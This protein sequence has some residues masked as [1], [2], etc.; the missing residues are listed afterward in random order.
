MSLLGRRA[1]AI[2]VPAEPPCRREKTPHARRKKDAGLSARIPPSRRFGWG[3]SNRRDLRPACR[4]II[5]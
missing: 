3:D 1:A 2:L 5:Q 4:Y